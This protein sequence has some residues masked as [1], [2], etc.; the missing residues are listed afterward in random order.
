MPPLM[1]PSGGGMSDAALNARHQ[2]RRMCIDRVAAASAPRVVELWNKNWTQRWLCF[3]ETEGSFKHKL[4]DAGEGHLSLIATPMLR[5]WMLDN[6]GTDEDLHVIVRTGKL[7][8]SGKCTGIT[9]DFRDGFP[10]LDIG[11]IHEYQHI[12]RILIY[13]NP[14][15]PAELQWPKIWATAGPSATCILLTI[16]LNLLRRFALPWT[17][18]DNIFDPGSWVKNLNPANWPM[19]VKPIGPFT[20]TSMWSVMCSQMGSAHD[21]VLPTLKDAGL[22]LRA[23]RWMPGDEQPAP[24]YY[25]LTKPTLVLSV[26]DV[27]GYKGLTGTVLD[28]LAYLILTVADDLINEVVT[29]VTG[30]A[31]PAE[32][33]K[34]GFK[35]TLKNFPWVTFRSL[36]R[37]WGISAITSRATTVHK[38][39]A[40]SVV[41]GGRSPQW[42]NSGI[43]LLLNATLGYVGSLIGNPNI[44]VDL[45]YPQ[46]ENVFL[47]YDRVPNPFRQQRMGLQGPPLGE[48]W[49]ATG[50]TGF[51][52][53]ALQSIRTGFYKSKAYT[54]TKVTCRNAEP[55]VVGEHFDL[56]H[57]VATEVGDSGWFYVDSA[58]EFDDTWSRADDPKLGVTIGDGALEDQP[59]AILARQIANIRAITQAT[60]AASA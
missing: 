34:P 43:K 52:L 7:R 35:G 53:S 36:D 21:M 24:D 55:Y 26:E 8:W 2:I 44:F 51:S 59:G 22:R 38:A 33:M 4:N 60:V 27:S 57:R 46:L 11:F 45:V 40:S 17:F 30:V 3:G 18:S 23:D 58:T 19:I 54:S 12:K 49:E 31:R 50:G 20:D 28:G 1:D 25:T 48:V 39:T 47:A 37:T 29:E 32:Y 41:T 10:R 14:F 6:L 13:K 9:D 56:G 42:V 16:F 5:K 15:L